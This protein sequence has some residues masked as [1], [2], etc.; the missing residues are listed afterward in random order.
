[1]DTLL[2]VF[3][4]ACE[5]ARHGHGTLLGDKLDFLTVQ[6]ALDQRASLAARM[7]GDWSEPFFGVEQQRQRYD[8]ERLK[9]VDDQ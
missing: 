5:A 2:C 6:R 4:G 1:M 3:F 8:L 7:L 9:I